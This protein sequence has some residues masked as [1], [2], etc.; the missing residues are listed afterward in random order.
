MHI[1]GR[2]KNILSLGEWPTQDLENTTITAEAKYSI[3][4]TKSEK[5][6]FVLSLH[7][8]GV[9]SF[10]FVNTIFRNKTISIIFR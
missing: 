6:R 5:K 8:N 2:N 9:N 10:L 4:V 3:N 1:D 7:Y